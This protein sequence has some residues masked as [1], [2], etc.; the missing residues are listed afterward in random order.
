MD[1]VEGSEGSMPVLELVSKEP[2]QPA[3]PAAC[4][5]YHRVFF[6]DGGGILSTLDWQVPPPFALCDPLACVRCAIWGSM[7]ADACRRAAA[8]PGRVLER[9]FFSDEEVHTMRAS[10]CSALHVD[11]DW[12]TQRFELTPYKLNLLESLAKRMDDP[13][14]PLCEVLRRGAPT[15]VRR[16]I[17]PIGGVAASLRPRM[18]GGVRCL[19]LVLVHRQSRFSG[20]GTFQSARVGSEGAGSGLHGSH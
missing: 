17:P 9:P 5:A 20:E 15:G 12:A 2:C 19:R 18:Q 8:L 11:L 1:L 13:D 7:P 3:D 16:P 6:K 14:V 10:V 4:A